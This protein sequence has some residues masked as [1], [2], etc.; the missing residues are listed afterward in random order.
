MSVSSSGCNNKQSTSFDLISQCK[1]LNIAKIHRELYEIYE[2]TIMN[3]GKLRKRRQEC[4]EGHINV[5]DK[6]R[7]EKCSAQIGNIIEQINATVLE[8]KWFMICVLDIKCHKAQCIE[9][10]LKIWLLYCIV[11]LGKI[12]PKLMHTKYKT[13]RMKSA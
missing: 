9:L 3:E 12:D 10:L 7:S 2:P 1:E 8:N 11:N 13:Q 5:H 4:N 6:Q